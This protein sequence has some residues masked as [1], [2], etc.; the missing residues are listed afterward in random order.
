MP[1]LVD[2]SVW[3]LALRRKHA[4]TNQIEQSIVSKLA[5]LVEQ[6]DI[7]II[8]AIRQEI[9]S[10]IAS[11]KAFELLKSKLAIFD[12]LPLTSHDYETAAACFNTCR[13]KGVQGSHTDFLLCA[14]ALNH[15]LTLF[16]QDNDFTH[17]AKYLPIRLLEV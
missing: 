12:D 4:P 7:V 15:E 16:A 3:S 9:L 8:G 14:V 13:K 17:Y 5:E 10:G 11:E 6:T 1:V 2:T